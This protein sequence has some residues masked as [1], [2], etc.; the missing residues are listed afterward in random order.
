MRPGPKKPFSIKKSDYEEVDAL[1]A[2]VMNNKQPQ[3]GYQIQ[4]S[5]NDEEQVKNISSRPQFNLRK[6]TDKGRDSPFIE[7]TE[8]NEFTS[9][10]AESSQS[11]IQSFKPQ[12]MAFKKAPGSLSHQQN[13]I[14]QLI[15]SEMQNKN[16][17]KKPSPYDSI[18]PFAKKT[19]LTT[20]KPNSDTNF[21]DNSNNQ[22]Q[23]L[24]NSILTKPSFSSRPI[25]KKEE[26]LI[27]P[28]NLRKQDEE[29]Q[30]IVQS[31]KPF[32]KKSMLNPSRGLKNQPQQQSEQYQQIQEQPRPSSQ[33][34]TI[35]IKK[36]LDTKI[37]QQINYMPIQTPI[38]NKEESQEYEQEFEDYVE[39]K[40]KQQAI[41]AAK[42]NLPI[43]EKGQIDWKE[44][45][46]KQKEQEELLRIQ[47]EQEEKRR[48][49]E[50]EERRIQEER[51]RD[52][53]ERRKD[54]Q[55][56]REIQKAAM[57]NIHQHQQHQ[58]QIDNVPGGLLVGKQGYDKNIFSAQPMNNQLDSYQQNFDQVPAQP[59]VQQA[60]GKAKPVLKDKYREDQSERQQPQQQQQQQQ[61]IQIETRNLVI[62]NKKGGMQYQN[63]QVQQ[64]PQ[65]QRFQQQ[66]EMQQQ[67]QQVLV[68]DQQYSKKQ[69]E[70]GYAKNQYQEEDQNIYNNFS[71][72]EVK[73][74]PQYDPKGEYIE[75][76]EMKVNLKLNDK[77]TSLA[78]IEA[79]QERV[80][81]LKQLI[82]LELDTFETLFELQP[83]TDYEIYINKIKAGTL[84]NS[85]DQSDDNRVTQE[86]QA[87]LFQQNEFGNQFPEDQTR[88]FLKTNVG[89][90]Q[91]VTESIQ[92]QTEPQIENVTKNLDDATKLIEFM[93][94]VYPVFEEILN[95]EKSNNQGNNDNFLSED[96]RRYP[97]PKFISDKFK[98]LG[99]RT[100]LNDVKDSY[101]CYDIS[102]EGN[103]WFRLSLIIKYTNFRVV[104]YC[105][106]QSQVS[107]LAHSNNILIAGTKEGSLN[108]WDLR[109][110]E[111]SH[112]K[113]SN[114]YI[115]AIKEGLEK[116]ESVINSAPTSSKSLAI[117]EDT[118][119]ASLAFRFPSFTTEYLVQN[120]NLLLNETES[121]QHSS[122]VVKIL[123]NTR[124]NQS[125]EFFSLEEFGKVIVWNLLELQQQ[126]AERNYIE[127]GKYTKIKVMSQGFINL[128]Q[129]IFMNPD[130]I[131]YDIQLD[132]EENN[133]YICSSLGIIK[134]DKFCT[135]KIKHPRVFGE[136]RTTSFPTCLFVSNETELLVAGYSDGSIKMFSKN[137][138]DPL[139]TFTN[140]TRQKITKIFVNQQTN[141]ST[142]K[143]YYDI[144]RLIASDATG[145][146]FL[147]DLS[148]NQSS[149]I[150]TYQQ[151]SKI[152]ASQKK[153]V[154]V[155]NIPDMNGV[156]IFIQNEQNQISSFKWN[157]DDLV[158]KNPKK[159]YE[160]MKK[161]EL[162]IP[163]YYHDFDFGGGDEI[164]I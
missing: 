106:T 94:N 116:N 21:E 17:L 60:K 131:C 51:R 33:T 93:N 8:D 144:N 113:V 70:F 151:I 23:P 100:T 135:N 90:A 154:S 4:Q 149:P 46:R 84:K 71:Q 31:I 53:E 95:S 29:D 66:N 125:L 15:Q 86:I 164:L 91:Q 112:Q 37:K 65:F 52:E 163:T 138:K 6:G 62:A 9:S 124:N 45:E 34:R 162:I 26:N 41:I 69:Q 72:K 19:N 161:L 11:Q 133:L 87:D 88:T 30:T 83:T 141:K 68:E 105:I 47:R 43:P 55:R 102:Q 122:S 2:N 73:L 40:P 140:F 77:K 5:Q 103:E 158:E 97:I 42:P 16:P 127:F 74:Q 153:A 57:I 146:I 28:A 118:F 156:E 132:S 3:K 117:D 98:I 1:I 96:V 110:T 85:A 20:S 54:E 18:K 155:Q 58:V 36:K 99:V 147:F 75:G 61:Q 123:I 143:K 13:E 27:E 32:D 25:R 148:I 152:N 101:I 78:K 109:E 120:A 50:E 14:D 38:I 59:S 139:L 145:N 64:Q 115:D 79:Q 142:N 129:Q 67:Q 121:V 89:V 108:L 160:D 22:E 49:E 56:R 48:K 81:N 159:I 134:A 82:Q 111:F 39:D 114:K 128:S 126:E 92:T 104:K 137:F 24:S 136:H 107:S 157:Y 35:N 119:E 80:K 7:S 12:K 63:E 150:K 130:S 76:D 44:Q 10:Q